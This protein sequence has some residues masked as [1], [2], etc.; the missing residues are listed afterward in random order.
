[1]TDLYEIWYADAKMGLLTASA[2]KNLNFT[3][4]KSRMTDGSNV[5]YRPVGHIL[6]CTVFGEW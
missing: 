1:L 5:H 3:N 4:H 6:V 2:I